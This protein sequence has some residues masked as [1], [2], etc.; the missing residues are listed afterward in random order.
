MISRTD[1]LYDPLTAAT[2]VHIL[3][4]KVLETPVMEV[5]F[6]DG[7]TARIDFSDVIKRS[8]WFHTLSVPTTFSDVEVV[9]EG[10]ALQWVTGAD[11][12]ADALRILADEQR[13]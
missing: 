12:C 10:R 3:G 4:I 11:Y 13:L 9:N 5:A 1:S 2:P 8:R 7:L 6:D